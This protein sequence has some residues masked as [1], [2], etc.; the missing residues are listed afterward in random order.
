MRVTAA[1]NNKQQRKTKQCS[2][3]FHR[4]REENRARNKQ[5]TAHGTQIII[6]FISFHKNLKESINIMKKQDKEKE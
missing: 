6:F 3:F 1:E 5:N 4:T 2:G